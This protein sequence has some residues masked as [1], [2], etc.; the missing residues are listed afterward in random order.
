MNQ[1]A[2]APLRVGRGARLPK[3]SMLASLGLADAN[4]RT[5]NLAVITLEC[6]GRTENEHLRAQPR[7]LAHEARCPHQS[8]NRHRRAYDP[9]LD[10]TNLAHLHI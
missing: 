10:M 6:R 8:G 9:Y 4:P 7:T 3:E 1:S 2:E 5:M